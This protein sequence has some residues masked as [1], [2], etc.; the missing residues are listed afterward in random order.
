VKTVN[1]RTT[2]GSLTV[3]AAWIGHHL[4]VHRPIDSKQ[5]D[6]LSKLPRWWR[7]SHISTGYAAGPGIDAAQ[8][9]VI[10]LAKLWDRAFASITAAGDA[11]GWKWRDRWADDLSRII[12]GKPLIGPRDL[13]PLEELESAGTAAAVENAVRRAMG[14]ESATD[15]E[16][17]QPFPA[18]ETVAADLLRTGEGWPGMDCPPEGWPQMFWRGQWWPVPTFG[19]VESWA[20][21]SVSET[22]DGRTVEPDAPDSWTRLLG[23]C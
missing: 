21:D 6:N 2:E 4:A 23:V 10:A 17:A 1:V 22:P 5:P 3:P 11:T 19:E 15:T 8:R 9:D 12:H 14:Y 16:A 20:L 18:H 13:T 7:I